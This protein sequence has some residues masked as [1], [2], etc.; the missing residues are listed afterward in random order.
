MGAE[1]SYE[2]Y[3]YGYQNAS[4]HGRPPPHPMSGHYSTTGE[5]NPAAYR[6]YGTEQVNLSAR[7][8]SLKIPLL[9]SNS[10]IV[11]LQIR[12]PE[13]LHTYENTGNLS[14][15]GNSR[16][17]GR[18]YGAG[19]SINHRRTS[20]NVSNSSISGII[21]LANSSN[22]NP[23]FRLEDEL[24]SIHVQP[25]A[26]GVHSSRVAFDLDPRTSASSNPPASSYR[27]ARQNSLEMERPGTLVLI[28]S[29]FY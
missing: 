21:G 25:A 29:G 1:R 22:I 3:G 12:P 18:L 4:D 11:Y 6:G 19:N 16:L 5:W 10:P 17:S 28:L 15:A 8:E 26:T 2:Q 23:S 13:S 24:D 14:S 20:S 9:L 27:I 7:V